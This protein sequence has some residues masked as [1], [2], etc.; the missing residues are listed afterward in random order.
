MFKMESALFIFY[1][2]FVCIIQNVPATPVNII[3]TKKVQETEKENVVK[4]FI[5]KE[6]KYEESREDEEEEERLRKA[7][8]PEYMRNLYKTLNKQTDAG[9]LHYANIVRSYFDQGLATT[10]MEQQSYQ[11]DI[12][13]INREREKLIKAELRI[14][15]YPN[16]KRTPLTSFVQIDVK[17]K[18]TNKIISSRILTSSGSGWQVFPVTNIVSAWISKEHLNKGVQLS[19]RPLYGANEEIKFAT[20]KT[21]R[22]EP[23]LVVYTKDSDD[24]VLATLSNLKQNAAAFFVTK[25]NAKPSAEESNLP[26]RVRRRARFDPCR[27]EELS[28]PLVQIGWHKSFAAPRKFRINQ[29][30]GTCGYD[31]SKAYHKQTNH[32]IIQALYATITGGRKT[33]YPCCAPSKFAPGNALIVDRMPSGEVVKVVS[34]E[35]LTVVQCQCL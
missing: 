32:A 8:I 16:R 6:K 18:N 2:L 25:T 1:A 29:C 28:V 17:D 14:F 24:L 20:K 10:E 11:F 31:A 9:L 22:R 35:K 34:L 12:V 23:I 21:V 26:R 15:K 7:H 33:S 4:S 13:D 30:K 27:V 19:V 5:A 3:G